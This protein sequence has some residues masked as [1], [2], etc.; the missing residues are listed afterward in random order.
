MQRLLCFR[1]KR[2]RKLIHETNSIPYFIFFYCLCKLPSSG[3][4]RLDTAS[5]TQ[6]ELCRYLF[7]QNNIKSE[8]KS[9]MHNVYKPLQTCKTQ[10]KLSTTLSSHVQNYST[11]C[12]RTLHAAVLK[13]TATVPLFSSW[14]HGMCKR[15]LK[16]QGLVYHIPFP[17]PHTAL[18]WVHLYTSEEC[19]NKGSSKFHWHISNIC[20]TTWHKSQ[21]KIWLPSLQIKVYVNLIFIFWWPDLNFGLG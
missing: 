15:C 1:K 12:G 10:H 13:S 4:I 17:L 7:L 11:V 8:L 5:W 2:R 18:V 21:P 20:Q 14:I 6:L 19:A 16:I 3:N 9:M